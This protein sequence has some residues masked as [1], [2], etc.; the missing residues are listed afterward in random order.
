MRPLARL[1]I[2]GPLMALVLP[3]LNVK[4]TRVDDEKGNVTLLLPMHSMVLE[5]AVLPK[6]EKIRL[7]RHSFYEGRITGN[8]RQRQERNVLRIKVPD[9]ETARFEIKTLTFVGP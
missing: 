1:L 9:G 6:G 7:K 8:A 2:L 5:A 3:A 4:V